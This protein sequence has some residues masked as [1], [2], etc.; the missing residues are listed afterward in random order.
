M[1][2]P[3]T[4]AA[5]LLLAPVPA[6]GV[7]A[8]VMGLAGVPPVVWGQNV[9]AVVLGVVMV[10]VVMRRPQIR[11]GPAVWA[12]LV[13]VALLAATL[14]TPGVD[15]VHRWLPIGPV[16]LHAAALLLPPTL[17]LLAGT[18]LVASA[19]VALAALLILLAQPDA[20]QACAFAAGWA[21]LAARHGRRVI[22][23]IALAL[24]L[25][26][27]CLL[28]PDPLQPVPHVE[29]VVGLAFA[30][31][32]LLGITS[33]AALLLV[34]IAIAVLLRLPISLALA[35]YTL[36]T[37]IAAWLG[38]FPVPMLGHGLSPILGYYLAVGVAHATKRARCSGD[39]SEHASAWPKR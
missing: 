28:R 17:V 30:D 1:F 23:P 27:V 9:A 22:L 16:R 4:R 15:G 3:R 6:V 31:A 12:T 35:T 33:V 24:A 34:P 20:A 37:L 8:V 19:S 11:R 14:L 13:M 7:G 21:C 5:L 29:G 18:G 10:F 36:G 2:A 32:P 38:H 25:A 39:G 26:A